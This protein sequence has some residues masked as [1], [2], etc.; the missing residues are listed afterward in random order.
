MKYST[1]QT[2]S[3][4]R[5]NRCLDQKCDGLGSPSYGQSECMLTAGVVLQ[6]R[7]AGAAQDAQADSSLQHSVLVESISGIETLKSARAE[8]QM[9]GRWRRYASMSAA[10]QEKM[11]RLT[12]V[13]VNLAS[14]SQQ[15]ISVGLVVGGFYLF[16][17]GKITMGAIIAIVMV[18]P[19]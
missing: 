11:R 17:D 8:G 12:A 5:G 3:F 4:S 16:N 10:T 18:R 14:I 13:A 2:G 6:R 1:F 9:L 7:M 15:A 19:A